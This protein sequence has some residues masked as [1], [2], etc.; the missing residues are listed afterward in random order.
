MGKK[1]ERLIN[2]RIEETRASLHRELRADFA[3]LNEKADS[4]MKLAEDRFK[5]TQQF[6]DVLKWSFALILGMITLLGLFS[7][8]SLRELDKSI[9]R[10]S[11]TEAKLTNRFNEA[12]SKVTN[13]LTQLDRRDDNAE[14][15]TRSFQIGF[16]T[17]RFRASVERL[18]LYG[19]DKTS[20]A[21]R[22]AKENLEQVKRLE[23]TFHET[24]D[25]PELNYIHRLAIDRLIKG[26]QVFMQTVQ[27]W[28]NLTS[29]ASS[30]G[31]TASTLK[32]IK[33]IE[34]LEPLFDSQTN[35]ISASMEMEHIEAST[36]ILMA[37]LQLTCYRRTGDTQ[38]LHAAIE[39]TETAIKLNSKF[40]KAYNIRGAIEVYRY[41]VAEKNG[42]PAADLSEYLAHASTNFSKSA[43][44]VSGAESISMQFNNLASILIE[45]AIHAYRQ[46]NQSSAYKLLD[47]ASVAIQK[48]SMQPYEHPMI[49]ITHAEL[50]SVKIGLQH[51]SYASVANDPCGA[52][53]EKLRTAQS[54]GV[55]LPSLE[56]LRTTNDCK[57]IYAKRLC[58]D[59]EHAYAQLLSQP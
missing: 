54:A 37:M 55:P 31:G 46:T 16:Y 47:E 49:H 20:D 59:I 51:T 7:F 58:P 10:V 48:S 45:R 14:I 52:I 36:R 12:E 6:Y 13:R 27:A 5:G 8:S 26:N 33:L 34:S 4:L 11:H 2:T 56:E 19:I 3:P 9:D 28:K 43:S 40:G 35:G 32:F 29:G 53:L 30:S 57:I 17:D 44:L 23:Q 50:E 1:S 24:T 15:L 41:Q 25:S 21:E 42:Q 22:A 38:Y 39:P 18:N